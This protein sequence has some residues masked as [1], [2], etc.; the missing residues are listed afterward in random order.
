[1]IYFQG[2]NVFFMWYCGGGGGSGSGDGSGGLVLCE[3]MLGNVYC[4]YVC[5]YF[6]FGVYL[7]FK[8]VFFKY[9]V[10]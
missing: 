7:E 5:G 8:F 4:E 6:V 10:K 1:M 3:Q 9:Y 2:N